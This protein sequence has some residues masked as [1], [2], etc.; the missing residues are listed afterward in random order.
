MKFEL[1]KQNKGCDFLFC[2]SRNR[3]DLFRDKLDTSLKYDDLK[4]KG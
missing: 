3:S 2:L 1:E 4:N